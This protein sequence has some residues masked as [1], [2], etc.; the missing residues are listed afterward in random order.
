MY[1]WQAT[2]YIY[3]KTMSFTK[4]LFIMFY[5]VSI[6]YHP[7]FIIFMSFICIFYFIL[8]DD[9]FW[10]IVLIITGLLNI[11]NIK[12]KMVIHIKPIIFFSISYFLSALICDIYVY[13]QQS[14]IFY[15]KLTS[16]SIL[17]FRNWNLFYRIAIFFN[18]KIQYSSPKK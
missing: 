15:T 11:I 4:C 16:I 5:T 6:H 17:N 12:K 3:T 10:K 13:K 1:K 18:P 7:D 2:L 8:L 9:Y 14:D